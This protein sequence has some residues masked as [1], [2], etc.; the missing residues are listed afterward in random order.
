MMKI[1]SIRM[2]KSEKSNEEEENEDEEE[3]DY[4]ERYT[5]KKLKT[6][7]TASTKA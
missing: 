4:E 6:D 3:E 2:K 5:K 1:I 7:Q